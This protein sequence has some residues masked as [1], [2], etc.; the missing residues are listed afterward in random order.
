M[1][2]MRM[3]KMRGTRPGEPAKPE[4]QL[5]LASVPVFART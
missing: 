4:R 1:S 5:T 3:E 2:F